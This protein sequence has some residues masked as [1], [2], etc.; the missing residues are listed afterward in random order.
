PGARLDLRAGEEVAV[1]PEHRPAAGGV[2]DDGVEL[3]DREGGE[4]LAGEVER[5]LLA[6]RMVMD[7]PAARLAGRDHDLAPVLLEDAG[8]R[9][10]RAGE[11][12]IADAAEEQDDASPPR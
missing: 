12:R 5:R 1:I 6:A 11:H 2:D 7:R 4:I 9:G 3:L 10:G 8:R